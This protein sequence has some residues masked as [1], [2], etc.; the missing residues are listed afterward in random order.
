MLYPS[1]HGQMR[2]HFPRWSIQ[3]CTYIGIFDDDTCANASTIEGGLA[4]G[5]I[6]ARMSSANEYEFPCFLCGGCDC[7]SFCLVSL[8]A[9][10][11]DAFRCDSSY[12]LL[13]SASGAKEL[14]FNESVG[15]RL[16]INALWH[17]LHLRQDKRHF[18]NALIIPVVLEQSPAA[19]STMAASKRPKFPITV[20]DG[21]CMPINIENML[22][23]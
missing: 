3:I 8:R 9:T 5:E 21:K 11:D 6:S 17:Q 2:R 4:S 12:R 18:P 13:S 15:T 20:A 19:Q 7:L 14:V 16:E 22:L 1:R 23:Y 10:G